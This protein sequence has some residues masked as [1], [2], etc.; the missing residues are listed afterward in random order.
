M[1]NKTLKLSS[2]SNLLS[3][4]IAV[5]LSQPSF[6]PTQTMCLSPS[7]LAVMSVKICLPQRVGSQLHPERT[8][9]MLSLMADETRSLACCC[10]FLNSKT[11]Y[12]KQLSLWLDRC[13]RGCNI[14]TDLAA[15]YC[16]RT[17]SQYIVPNSTRLKCSSRFVRFVRLRLLCKGFLNF[18]D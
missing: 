7:G 9:P 13:S 8:Y 4:G 17:Q 15:A 6:A 12:V 3:Q 16:R 11:T 14:K 5:G 10:M 18:T 1:C 2:M